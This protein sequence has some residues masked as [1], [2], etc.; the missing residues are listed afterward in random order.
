ML[1][2]ELNSENPL[3]ASLKTDK[4]KPLFRELFIGLTRKTPK[5]EIEKAIKIKN[6][7][8]ADKE[9]YQ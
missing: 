2:K 5:S 1:L 6:E 7:Y 4:I 8:Y 3:R 9:T